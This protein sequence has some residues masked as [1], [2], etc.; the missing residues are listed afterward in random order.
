MASLRKLTLDYCGIE[1][2]CVLMYCIAVTL[3]DIF[4]LTGL[5]MLFP[6]DFVL[7]LK[8][9]IIFL[10]F[11]GISVNWLL[12]YAYQLIDILLELT[13]FLGYF[14]VTLVLM[15]HSC[16]VIDATVPS[17]LKLEEV[18]SND[19]VNQSDVRTS[20]QEVIEQSLGVISWM[21][22][23]RRILR[24]SFLSEITLLSSILCMS[25]FTFL[26]SPYESLFVLALGMI[27]LSQF[28]VYCWIG[29]R[30]NSRLAQFANAIY[31][32]RWDKMTPSQR[33]DL[34]LVLMMTQN[35]KG[36]NAVFKPVDLRSLQNVNLTQTYFDCW[37][38]IIFQFFLSLD[39]GSD[40]LIDS[41]AS[42]NDI[43]AIRS[44]LDE[45]YR[46]HKALEQQFLFCCIH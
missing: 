35:I 6:N 43:Q 12:N 37:K 23:T 22:E 36:F 8:F 14:C 16:W 13:Y 11:D 33:R 3:L 7:P 26:S 40:L 44:R 31:N 5:V 38:K 9:Q 24:L 27:A 17:V 2:K 32:C 20:I 29:S 19:E 41:F 34:Q 46:V 4:S 21:N 25:I 10:P 18:L 45:K 1:F 30:V 39:I 15:N 42:N 28:A